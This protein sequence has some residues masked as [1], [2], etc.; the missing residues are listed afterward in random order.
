MY[1]FVV[2]LLDKETINVTS[3]DCSLQLMELVPIIMRGITNE[4]RQ[5]TMPGLSM[6]QYRTLNYLQRHPQASLSDV[7]AFLGLTLP[8]TSKLVQKFVAQKIVTRRV[9]KD[10]RRVCLSLTLEGSEALAHARQETHK[11]LMETLSCLTP[12]E[13]ATVATALQVLNG[14]F[15]GGGPG[16]NLP[17]TI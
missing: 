15:T 7:A 10:R 3:S 12:E 4:M 16:V 5:R 17:Q 6:P 9:A 13:L 1:T 2:Q 11:K 8:S 14:A